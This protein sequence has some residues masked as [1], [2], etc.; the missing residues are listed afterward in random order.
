M[1]EGGIVLIARL[2]GLLLIFI[3]EALTLTLISDLWPDAALD[4]FSSGKGR[5][6]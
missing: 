4:E 2:L 1:C 3:G 5:K 6:A